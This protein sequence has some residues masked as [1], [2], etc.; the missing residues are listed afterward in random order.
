MKAIEIPPPEDLL[1]G[2]E[3]YP[4]GQ[5]SI[6][7]QFY[8]MSDDSYYVWPYIRRTRGDCYTEKH[9]QMLTVF[10]NVD[11]ARQAAITEGTALISAG[12]NVNLID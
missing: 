11:E 2:N 7:I 9:F 4:Q 5:H 12:F 10:S 3:E 1:V 6:R 8:K